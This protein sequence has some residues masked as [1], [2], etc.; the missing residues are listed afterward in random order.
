MRLLITYKWKVG[1]P[2]MLIAAMGVLLQLILPPQQHTLFVGEGLS[3]KSWIITTKYLLA[4]TQVSNAG[5]TLDSTQSQK[6]TDVSPRASLI[7]VSVSFLAGIGLVAVLIALNLTVSV[8]VRQ[9]ITIYPATEF[10]STE[11]KTY[12]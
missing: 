1:L 2:N 11:K 6:C 12:F 5:L 10:N 4:T 8:R 3:F 9:F 7:I